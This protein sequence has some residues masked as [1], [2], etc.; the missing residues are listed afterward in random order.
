M[1]N[2]LA[3]R[4]TSLIPNNECISL[5]TKSDLYYQCNTQDLLS[6]D[7]S[8]AMWRDLICFLFIIRLEI[9]ELICMKPSKIDDVLLQVMLT[10][11]Q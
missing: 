1:S 6:W 5:R 10:L 9:S 7:W 4:I 3:Q 2:H 11:Y 8:Y